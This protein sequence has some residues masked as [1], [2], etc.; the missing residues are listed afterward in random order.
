M[1]YSG[2]L[3]LHIAA[4]A[5]TDQQGGTCTLELAPGR[6]TLAAA[7]TG[8]GADASAQPA[9]APVRLLPGAFTQL[10][11]GSRPVWWLA[12]QPGND[13]PDP[14][15]PLLDALFPAE[16]AWIAATDGF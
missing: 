12:E 4:D 7:G 14:A 11:F 13:I 3:T 15:R 10:L 5:A 16:P 2:T 9:D 6:L 8:D 1:A